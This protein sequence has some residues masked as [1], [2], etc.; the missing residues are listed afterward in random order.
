MQIAM[1]QVKQ[2]D[3]DEKKNVVKR[4][5]HT[6]EIHNRETD[7]LKCFYINIYFV[8]VGSILPVCTFSSLSREQHTKVNIY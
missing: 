1:R 4:D 8:H 7:D 5:R 6:N 2:S 3:S